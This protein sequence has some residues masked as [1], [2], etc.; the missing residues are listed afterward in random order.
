[1][2]AVIDVGPDVKSQLDVISMAEMPL[3]VSF[4]RE[5]P[6][7]TKPPVSDFGVSAC[8]IKRRI[9]KRYPGWKRH[10]RYLVFM[11]FGRNSL[12]LCSKYAFKDLPSNLDNLDFMKLCFSSVNADS[13]S[14]FVTRMLK[15]MLM[16]DANRLYLEFAV[17]I[18]QHF[19]QIIPA[20]QAMSAAQDEI[21]SELWILYC[22]LKLTI[23]KVQLIW[24]LIT[25]KLTG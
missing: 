9:I 2:V 11:I 25:R 21:N 18:V 15:D 8:R 24:I 19:E 10:P 13:R 6:T 20:F 7:Q 17:R 3:G 12:D 16:D 22:S 1:M 14:D 5:T 4:S 23:D